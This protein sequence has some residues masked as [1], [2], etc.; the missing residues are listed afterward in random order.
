[1]KCANCDKKIGWRSDYIEI[2]DWGKKW[3]MFLGGDS[4]DYCSNKCAIEGLQKD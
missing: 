4:K 1:M 2:V 3:N